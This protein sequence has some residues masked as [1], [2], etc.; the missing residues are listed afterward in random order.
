MGRGEGKRVKG[1]HAKEELMGGKEVGE[2]VMGCKTQITAI[3]SHLEKN[4]SIK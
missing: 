1:A 2:S 3:G 4:E